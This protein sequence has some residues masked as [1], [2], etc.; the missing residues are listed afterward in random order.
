LGQYWNQIE[1]LRVQR[2]EGSQKVVLNLTGCS[3][4]LSAYRAVGLLSARSAKQRH[5]T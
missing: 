4:A 1:A 5:T 2:S 3:A